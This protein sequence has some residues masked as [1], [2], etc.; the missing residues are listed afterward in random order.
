MVWLWSLATAWGQ[1]SFQYATIW[2]KSA[3]T[4]WQARHGLTAAEYQSAFTT[5]ANQG[6]RLT[7]VSGYAV[8]GVDYYAAIWDKS[9]GPAWSA[10]HRLTSA[11]HQDA[12]NQLTGQG[13]RPIRISAYTVSG[14]DYY[15]SI[16]VKDLNVPT[17]A[18]H[19]MNAAQYQTAFN[20]Y[21]AQGY[22]LVDISGYSLNGET[23]YAALWQKPPGVNSAWTASHGLTADQFQAKFTELANQGY[24]LRV[25]NGYEVGGADRYVAIWDKSPSAAWTARHRVAG[26]NYQALFN[27]LSGQGYH[28]IVVSGYAI[29]P[30]T[31]PDIAS[32]GVPVPELRALDDAMK[33]FMGPRDIPAGVLCVSKNG[34]LVF[35][36]AYGW[37]DMAKTVPLKPSAMFRIAS[38]CKPITEAAIRK[39]VTAKQLKLEQFVF[40]LGQPGGGLL[41]YTPVGTPDTRLKQVT[42]AHLMD[43]KGGWDRDLSGDPMLRAV[44]IAQALGTPS[45]ASSRDIVRYMMGRPLDHAPGTTYAYSNFGYLLLGLI[46]EQLTGMDYVQY[47]HENVFGPA[48]VEDS[49]VELGRSLPQFRN[50]RE[51]WYSDPAIVRN[52]FAPALNV[53]FPDGGFNLEPM[54]AH[55]GLISTA[56]AYSRFLGKYWIDGQPRVGNGQTWTFFGSLPGT[57]TL[58]HQRVDGVD[59]VAFFNQRADASGLSYDD[60]LPSLNAAASSVVTWPTLD[61]A[62]SPRLKPELKL[63]A[64]AGVL[65]L[66]TT[67]VGRIYR[68]ESS[69]ELTTWGQLG[70]HQVGDGKSVQWEV[71]PGGVGGKAAQFY[72]VMVE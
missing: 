7:Q 71:N 19:R 36:R 52:V 53:P 50:D 8:N 28:P 9:A 25:I 37:Q 33:V 45:P 12:F 31:V 68:L 42:V 17:I 26:A 47:I 15:A 6:Y 13:Y 39:L 70:I 27:D 11:Q 1:Q 29:G 5:L 38:L 55:G 63:D 66:G 14:V 62:E 41:K 30:T 16:W 60:I 4:A 46:L 21:A 35:E 59:I 43:H 61:I 54:E 51:P 34:K 67:E 65:S 48:G 10:R 20:D 69:S 57:W 58:G 3:T 22:R 64:V 56:R 49:E 24:R 72:R 44:E 32:S 2:D 18:R 23:M 40:D